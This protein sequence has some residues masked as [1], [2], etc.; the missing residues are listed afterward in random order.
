MCSRIQ[1]S[2]CLFMM[3]IMN[4]VLFRRADPALLLLV[5][6][7]SKGMPK[8]VVDTFPSPVNPLPF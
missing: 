1:F 8:K 7:A 4:D 6:L 3:L 5:H 2:K